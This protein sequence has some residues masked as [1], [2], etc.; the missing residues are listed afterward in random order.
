LSLNVSLTQ[1]YL[2][3]YLYVNQLSSLPTEIGL[4]S[5]LVEL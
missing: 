2:N 5:N 1:Y 3:S 4:L